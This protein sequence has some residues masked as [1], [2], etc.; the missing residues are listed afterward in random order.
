M[1]APIKRIIPAAGAA[2]FFLAAALAGVSVYVNSTAFGRQVVRRIDTAIAGHF[3]I[4]GHELD[5]LAGTLTLSGVALSDADG[6]AIADIGQLHVGI[7]WPALAWRTLSI[8]SVSIEQAR[9]DLRSDSGHRMNVTDALAVSSQKPGAANWIRQVRIGGLR[10]RNGQISYRDPGRGWSGRIVGLQA[11]GRGDAMRRDGRVKISAE[12]MSLQVPGLDRRLHDITLDIHYMDGPDSPVAVTIHTAET[13]LLLE[14]KVMRINGDVQVN[15]TSDLDLTLAQIRPWLSRSIDMRGRLTGKIDLSGRLKDPSATLRLKVANARVQGVPIR[16]AVVNARMAHRQITLENVDIQSALGRMGVSGTIDLR[17]V[18]PHSFESQAADLDALRYDLQIYGRQMEPG[19]ISRLSFLRSGLWQGQL[20]VQGSGLSPDRVKGFGTIDLQADGLQVT[21]GGRPATAGLTATVQ[22]SD[23]AVRIAQ[24]Q[25]RLGRLKLNGSGQYDWAGRRFDAEA[26]AQSDR[27]AELGRLLGMALPDGKGTLRLQGRGPVDRPV[28]HAELVSQ[29]LSLASWRL[30]GLQV[31]ADLGADGI[32]QVSRL[33]LK[34]SGSSMH[35]QG[36]VVLLARDGTLRDDPDLD[37]NFDL[38]PLRWSDFSDARAQGDLLLNGKLH[39]GGRLRHP[40]AD[41]AVAPSPVRWETV[42]ARIEG[43]AR[44]EN[45]RLDVPSLALTRGR[46]LVML[47]GSGRWRDP[48]TG[49]WRTDPLIQADLNSER[50]FL[51]DWVPGRSGQLAIKAAVAGRMPDLRGTYEVRG[52]DL[53]SG[54]QTFS[55]VYLA[56]RFSDRTVFADRIAARLG[57]G[58]SVSGNGWYA[59]DQRF[60]IQLNGAGIA[61]HQIDALRQTHDV[62][63]RLSFSV[64]ARGSVR[65]P[66]LEGR[67]AVHDPRIGGRPFNDF[68]AR[69]ALQNRLLT[70]QADLNFDLAA[71]YRLDNGDFDLSGVFDHTDLQPYLAML[72]G[73]EWAGRLTGRVR[74]TGNRDDPDSIDAHVVLTQTDLLYRQVDVLH[75]DRLEATVTQG[76][77]SMPATRVKLVKDGELT[78]AA[79]GRLGQGLTVRSRGDLPLAALV[80]FTERIGEPAGRIHIAARGQGPWNRMQWQGQAQFEQVGFQWQAWDQNVHAV[81]GTVRIGP[82]EIVVD[83][84]SGMLDTGRFALDGRLK[85]SG[86][87]PVQG[88]LALSAK[89]LP[90][91]WRDTLD[92]TIGA[93]L[94]LRGDPR[95]PALEGS[96]TLLEGAYYKDVSFN[97]VSRITQHRRAEPVPV[98]TWSPP[99]WFAPVALNVTVGY[100]YPLLVD[101]NVA[102]LNV[103]PDFEIGGTAAKPVLTGRAGVTEG[104]LYFRGKTFTIKRGVV[105]FV[106]PYKIEPTLDVSAVAQIRKW[107]VTLTASGPPDNLAVQLS[108]DP[109]ESDSNI[110]SLILLGRTSEELSQGGGGSTPEQMLASLAETAWGESIKKRTGVDILEVETGAKEENQKADRIQ[111]TVGKYLSPRFTVKYSVEATGGETIQ[112]AT[113]EY[114][115]LENILASGFQ[116]TQGN[117]GGELQFRIEFR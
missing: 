22:W 16:K 30:G 104:E 60:Q 33:V 35:G 91:H 106:N 26:T 67:L 61:L 44:W 31:D 11:S 96:V 5:L 19:R 73:K 116:D 48:A 97:L 2:V 39:L 109:A 43:K 81:E 54:V 40:V 34:N 105:D 56:G 9:L 36:R 94:V 1:K 20:H 46:S 90:V 75:L 99:Q 51:Q 113:S 80:P 29:D 64:Q 53:D 93:D 78:I 83:H 57:P 79:E 38:A 58:Q 100:R 62:Q 32:V 13:S 6:A 85:L 47:Q 98:G 117:Y 17:P 82:E 65:Q 74:A 84:L 49:R 25:A 21:A 18:F 23:R 27:L 14:G 3:Q 15:L 8:S 89:A 55:S 7:F 69:V 110:L 102:R 63:G 12:E 112:R 92:L 88:R 95:Q 70:V 68:N 66:V 37:L 41:L 108:S 45:G 114:K 87:L 52:S 103:T 111:V 72:A 86:R 115:L 107:Q 76:V 77:L 50:V 71:R 101:N 10:L 28:V 4:Q 59:L 42:D 24:G